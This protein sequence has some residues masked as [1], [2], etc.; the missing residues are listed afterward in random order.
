MQIVDEVIKE[1]VGG[2][3]RNKEQILFP[4]KEILKKYLEEFEG[5]SR[6]EIFEERKEKTFFTTSKCFP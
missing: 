5:Y 4:T 3:H 2:A 1:P 6:E